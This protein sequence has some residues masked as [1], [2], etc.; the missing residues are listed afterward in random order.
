MPSGMC[1]FSVL[2]ILFTSVLCDS[3]TATCTNWTYFNLP[4]SWSGSPQAINR[5]STMVGIAHP[6]NRGDVTAYGFVRYLNGGFKTYAVPNASATV[7]TRRNALGVTV[8]WY[9]DATSS[10]HHHGV[11]FSGSSMATVNYPGATDTVLT[12]INFGAAS[13]VTTARTPLIL[14]TD[15]N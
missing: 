4:A 13:W 9:I 14:S 6:R 15:L 10:E 1:L 11:V 8:G 7:F 3:Q 12:G 2:L 5:W